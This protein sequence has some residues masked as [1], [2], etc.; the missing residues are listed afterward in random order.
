MTKNI[1]VLAAMCLALI[2]SVVSAGQRID[3]NGGCR[4]NP[5]LVASCFT[6]H[7]RLFVGN[8]APSMRIWRVGTKRILGVLPSEAEIVPADSMRRICHQRGR[9]AVHRREGR[10]RGVPSSTVRGGDTPA[11]TQME[12]TR[13]TFCAVLSQRRAAQLER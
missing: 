13:R 9:R 3:A 10:A 7:G 8:G 1:A 4:R 2:N 5:A 6:L 11:N 12:P